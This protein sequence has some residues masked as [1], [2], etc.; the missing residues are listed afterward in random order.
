[1]LLNRLGWV[2]QTLIALVLA[3]IIALIIYHFTHPPKPAK[4]P[5]THHAAVSTRTQRE[6]GDHSNIV[7]AMPAVPLAAHV[8]QGQRSPSSRLL[9]I[10]ARNPET[11]KPRNP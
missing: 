1:M 10:V 11:Q 3:I 5:G 4:S 8:D 9:T 2:V 6:Q 7:L